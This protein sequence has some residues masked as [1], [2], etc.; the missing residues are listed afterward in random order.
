MFVSL[1]ETRRTKCL[2]LALPFNEEEFGRENYSNNKSKAS[3]LT[4]I[5][6]SQNP[7]DLIGVQQVELVD[8]L[9]ICKI[10][11]LCFFASRLK[12]AKQIKY[13]YYGLCIM[14]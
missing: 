5:H 7:E 2:A 9:Y 1:P 11:I 4:S 10:I 14:K 3:H 12:R 13:A 8:K 6:C